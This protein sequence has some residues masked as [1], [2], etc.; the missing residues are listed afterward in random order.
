MTVVAVV[1]IFEWPAGCA[2]PNPPDVSWKVEGP[3]D[4]GTEL[5][6]PPRVRPL[7]KP[8]VRLRALTACV[9]EVARWRL[10]VL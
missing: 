8:P 9:N 2:A 3:L 4:C 10:D 1:A 6:K 5:L 7:N